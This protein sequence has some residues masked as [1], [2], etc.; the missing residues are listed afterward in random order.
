MGREE[1]KEDES[2]VTS[3]QLPAWPQSPVSSNESL[4]LVDGRSEG[5]RRGLGSLAGAQTYAF[6]DQLPSEVTVT[7][8]TTLSGWSSLSN[9]KNH[10][11]KAMS[12]AAISD[13]MTGTTELLLATT[14]G[15]SAISDLLDDG[16]EWLVSE[17]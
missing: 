1:G 10:S 6:G 5:C 4:G 14:T 15:R 7:S 17:W 11:V 3:F 2:P 8:G 16:D 12:A 9:T 13:R